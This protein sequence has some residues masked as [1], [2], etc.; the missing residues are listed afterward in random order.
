MISW[1]GSEWSFSKNNA[2][3]KAQRTQ[4]QLNHELLKDRHNETNSKSASTTDTLCVEGW[5][6]FNSKCYKYVSFESSM[7]TKRRTWLNARNFCMSIAPNS[8][9]MRDFEIDL[10]SVPDERTNNFLKDLKHDKAW[11][12]GYRD[13]VKSN[14]WKWS[15][16]TPMV[17]QSW[18][19]REPSD[20]S[21]HI[22]INH[23]PN[24]ETPW[25][26]WD[27]P[28]NYKINEIKGFFCQYHCEFQ[29]I[30]NI[31]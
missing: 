25:G 21:E 26:Q 15:D 2:R 6:S 16:G 10:A 8:E 11:I 17:Y 23:R 24:G 22:V 19:S 13:E 31:V 14:Q 9:S 29:N 1:T 3:G 12:G 20:D 28:P 4:I 7:P 30:L 27:D 5:K 18:A